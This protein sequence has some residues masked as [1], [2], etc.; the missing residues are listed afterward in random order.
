MPG[1]KT[2]LPTAGERCETCRYWWLQ[3]DGRSGPADPLESTD[4]PWGFCR[5]YPPAMSAEP[6]YDAHDSFELPVVAERDGC[7]E[8]RA[9]ADEVVERVRSWLV[10]D[11]TPCERKMR[12]V[13]AA[14]MDEL[15]ADGMSKQMG[16]TVRVNLLCVY[17]NL[18]D[19][20]LDRKLQWLV[21]SKA[22][23][24]Q[25]MRS[26]PIT[27]AQLL[28]VVIDEG[29]LTKPATAMAAATLDRLTAQ[30]GPPAPPASE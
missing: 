11:G 27:P 8:W 17:K 13:I 9:K 6:S 15:I 25:Q 30:H 19:L 18:F 1:D 20:V 26:M 14:T 12:E 7:G 21:S 2:E 24:L 16:K 22:Y 5:R 4:E 10:F 28:T 3:F 29:R 23:L